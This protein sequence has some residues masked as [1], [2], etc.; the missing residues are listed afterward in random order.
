[1]VR[2]KKQSAEEL[3]NQ[4][5]GQQHQWAS[6]LHELYPGVS[7]VT[8]NIEFRRDEPLPGTPEPKMM[9]FTSEQKAFFRMA[10][11]SEECVRGGF[12]F[13]KGVEHAIHNPGH[14][15]TGRVICDGWQDEEQIN[16]HRCMLAASYKVSVE[17][18]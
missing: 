14:A 4:Q 12:D 18:S 15:S 5:F 3:H 7:A 6:S 11:P 1:M 9:R 2:K 17:H 16:K 10:C 8:I 13:S